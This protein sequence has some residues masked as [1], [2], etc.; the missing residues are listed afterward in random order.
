MLGLAQGLR[1][2]AS[3]ATLSRPTRGQEGARD[4]ALPE[5]Q[6]REKTI[7]KR[8]DNRQHRIEKIRKRIILFSVLYSLFSGVGVADAAKMCAYDRSWSS[9]SGFGNGE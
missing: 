6:N 3:Q 8:T 4:K 9:V 1:P 2:F 7:K 5:K